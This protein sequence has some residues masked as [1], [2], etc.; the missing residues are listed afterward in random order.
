MNVTNSEPSKHACTEH[1]ENDHGEVQEHND[2]AEGVRLGVGQL[3]SGQLEAQAGD[4][5]EMEGS[6]CKVLYNVVQLFL[7]QHIT[8]K[9]EKMMDGHE[10]Q[11]E[12]VRTLYGW[13]LEW[14]M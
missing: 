11:K 4:E 1:R 8:R 13:N 2:N 14:R 3:V 7:K 6:H 10:A 5:R 12:A 9:I